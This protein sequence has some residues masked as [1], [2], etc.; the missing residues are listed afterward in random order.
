[1]NNFQKYLNQNIIFSFLIVMALVITGCSKVGEEVNSDETVV[2]INLLGAESNAEDDLQG[3]LAKQGSS[4]ITNDIQ[5][6]VI[7]FD[8]NFTLVATLSP[9]GTTKETNSQQ[10]N[11]A[12]SSGA[13]AA[14]G[15]VRTNLAAN[16]MYRV[17]VYN[18][19][20]ALVQQKDYKYG[21]EATVG[22]F[23]LDGETSYT[24]IAYSVNS[25]STLPAVVNPNSLTTV[26]VANVTGD[27]MYFKETIKIKKGINNLNV[28]LKH[29]FS[30]ITTTVSLDASST[31]T[32]TAIS[33]PVLKST[34]TSASINLNTGVLTYNTINNAGIPLVFGALNVRSV[35]AAPVQII[36][37]A[38][39]NGTFDIGAITMN[40]LTKG[41]ISI[42]NLRINPGC[43]YNLI[44]A[45][46]APCTQIVNAGDFAFSVSNG[47]TKTFSAPAADFGFS[48]DLLEVDNSF[49]LRIN[50]TNLVNQEI[51]FEGGQGVAGG[52]NLRFADGTYWGNSGIPQIYDMKGTTGKPIIRVTIDG[53][54]KVAMFGSKSAGGPLF[55]LVLSGTA[56]FNTI[57]WNKTAANTVIASQTVKGP[58]YLV[59]E[60]YGKKIITCPQ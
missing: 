37:P 41:P 3:K 17:L 21:N 31:G 29:K 9:E 52:Q 4:S 35:S 16:V 6:T 30:Q 49:N 43:K 57:T 58:T 42:P 1:M 7:P 10:K 22:G 20:G 32:V 11:T 14:T 13:R 56:A 19:A 45:F 55:P 8:D 18:A 34:Y 48:F 23:I 2:N 40:G 33:A 5:T 50:G 53:N 38:I 24:F 27:L 26:N 47:A 60:G 28:I 12:N 39:T 59:G 36:T 54:G 25:T 44:L 51:E 46:V 15:P